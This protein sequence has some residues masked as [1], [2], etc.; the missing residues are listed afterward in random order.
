MHAME[1]HREHR[2][3]RQRREKG[4]DDQVGEVPDQDDEGIEDELRESLAR[5]VGHGLV[6]GEMLLHSDRS[7]KSLQLKI[8]DPH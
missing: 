2:G 3:P 6:S 4:A 1:H 7:T 5:V 8:G